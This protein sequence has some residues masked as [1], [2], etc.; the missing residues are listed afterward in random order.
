MKLV[1]TTL[2]LTTHLLLHAT[3]ISIPTTNLQV[4]HPHANCDCY[5]TS[6]ITSNSPSNLTT[7]TYFT[8]YRFWDFRN[9][10]LPQTKP[11]TT[12]TNP[13]NP[14]D[15][16]TLEIYP[17]TNTLFSHD[18]RVQTWDR[19]AT[20]ISPVPMKNTDGNVFLLKHPTSTPKDPRS[21]FL[22]LRTTRFHDHAST[23]EM[24]GLFGYI[25]HCSLR[26]RMR[27]MSRDDILTAAAAS[28]DTQAVSQTQTKIPR[29]SCAGIFTYRSSICESDIEILTTED[30]HTI[31]Y[32]NQPD[33]DP[34]SDTIIPGAS[35]IVNLSKPW[36]SWTTHRLD[37]V[38]DMSAWYAD[39]Q[40]Q[41]KSNYSVPDRP[42]IVAMNLWS[43]GGNWSGDMKV[44]ESVFMGIEW[45]ELVYNVTK[46]DQDLPIKDHP[47]HRDRYHRVGG[48]ASASGSFAS[49][50]GGDEDDVER[51]MG[52]AKEKGG[53]CQRPCWIDPWHPV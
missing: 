9:A 11:E 50:V 5:L 25:Y 23:A 32:A 38:A 33:Y 2:I 30:T 34:I 46:A 31:H 47:G 8:H 49:S 42:S 4:D 41:S 22:V 20:D 16:S 21:S 12:Q 44:G 14:H 51:K 48:S 45:I 26:L 35:S 7:P 52:K 18:W 19:E 36:T 13:S 53:G 27:M 28:S 29:G 10:P 39:G 6:S 3:A 43:N 17:L 37:W 40:V 15:T 24:E 1:L